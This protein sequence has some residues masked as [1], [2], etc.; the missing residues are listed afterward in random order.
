MMLS[1]TRGLGKPFIQMLALTYKKKK[2]MIK[3]L[4]AEKNQHELTSDSECC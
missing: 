1:G 3:G 2:K 4:K